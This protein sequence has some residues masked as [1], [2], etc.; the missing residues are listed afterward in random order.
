M[1]LKIDGKVYLI[2]CLLLCTKFVI[3]D[4]NMLI[5]FQQFLI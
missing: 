3:T 1:N 4:A 5:K 2:D